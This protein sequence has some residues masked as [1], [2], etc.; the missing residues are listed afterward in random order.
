MKRIP[1]KRPVDRGDSG[2]IECIVATASL[3]VLLI[4][5]S[6]DPKRSKVPRELVLNF[7]D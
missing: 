7:A 5:G 4:E 2:R 3:C 1:K 6:P